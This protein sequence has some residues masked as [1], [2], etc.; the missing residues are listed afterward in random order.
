[1]AS[2]S[3]VT[4]TTTSSYPALPSLRE[5]REPMARVAAP[6]GMDGTDLRRALDDDRS[7]DDLAAEKRAENTEQRA[8][9]RRADQRATERLAEQRTVERRDPPPDRAPAA[10]SGDPAYLRDDDKLGRIG[11]LMD[12]D[13]TE[14]SRRATSGSSLI[15]MLQGNN[16]DLSRLRTVLDSGDLL[17]VTV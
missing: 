10:G 7:R 13:A 15:S 2:I 12:M 6:R 9:E 8:T 3:A 14:V 16:V 11:E 4:T 17:D 5:A 1:M